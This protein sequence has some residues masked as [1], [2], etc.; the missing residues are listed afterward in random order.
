MGVAA[1]VGWKQH[2]NARN[3]KIERRRIC[4]AQRYN[5]GV[6]A[7]FRWERILLYEP[8]MQGVTVAVYGTATVLSCLSALRRQLLHLLLF[9]VRAVGKGALNGRVTV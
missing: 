6:R 2:K 3:R 9:D 5:R 1:A 7:I 8:K 4:N